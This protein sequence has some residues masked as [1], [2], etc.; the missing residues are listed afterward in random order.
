MGLSKEA[1]PDIENLSQLINNRIN[2]DDYLSSEGECI[3]SEDEKDDDLS[4]CCEDSDENSDQEDSANS[5][6]E[7]DSRTQSE[8]NS[9]MSNLSYETCEETGIVQD[10]DEENSDDGCKYYRF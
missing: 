2:T 4:F 5:S 7:S 10:Y 6:Q 3:Y 9:N 1:L 8:T